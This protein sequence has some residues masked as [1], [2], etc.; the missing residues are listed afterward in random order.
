MYSV[1]KAFLPLPSIEV[2][3]V[4]LCLLYPNKWLW[5]S[6]IGAIGTFI[7]GAIGYAIGYNLGHKSMR[8]MANAKD[9]EKGE[10]LMNRY[11]VIAVFIGGITPIPDFLLAYLAGLTHMSFIAFALSDAIARFL[12]SMIVA[13][14]LNQL[15]MIINFDRFGTYFSFFIIFILFLRWGIEKFKAFRLQNKR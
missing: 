14:L 4:P 8:Y 3:F 13:F 7:G 6:L 5:Y 12:R 2:I 10:S 1:L 15:N 11:G 9:I